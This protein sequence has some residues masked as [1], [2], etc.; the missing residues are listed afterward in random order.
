SA[1]RF[2]DVEVKKTVFSVCNAYFTDFVANKNKYIEEDGYFHRLAA[3]ARVG[4]YLAQVAHANNRKDLADH[5]NDQLKSFSA[6]SV[7]SQRYKTW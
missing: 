6:E 1:N 4:V 5:Y 7:G 2:D 3:A